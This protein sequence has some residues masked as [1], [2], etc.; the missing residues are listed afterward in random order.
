MIT[1]RSRGINP[2]AADQRV[3]LLADE[4]C[5]RRHEREV[6][7]VSCGAS[8]LACGNHA[9]ELKYGVEAWHEMQKLLTAEER[10]LEPEDL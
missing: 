10:W 2:C 8:L 6:R 5:T 3:S 9:R 4:I 7:D 1:W